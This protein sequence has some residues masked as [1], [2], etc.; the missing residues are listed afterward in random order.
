MFRIVRF[1]RDKEAAYEAQQYRRIEETQRWLLL[2]GGVLYAALGFWLG[3]GIQETT[4]GLTNASVALLLGSMVMWGLTFTPFVRARVELVPIVV[5]LVFGWFLIFAIA[6]VPDSG[7]LKAALLFGSLGALT[8]LMSPMVQTAFAAMITALLMAAVG[9][10]V[11]FPLQGVEIGLFSTL[12]VLAPV[13]LFVAGFALAL[14]HTRREAF[15][16]R[17]ELARRAT[18]DDISGVS[19]RAHIHQIAQNEF[20]RARRYKEPLSV[21]MLE[22]DNFDKILDDSGP[23]ALDTL[24]QVF[25]GYCVVVMRHCDSFGRLGPKRFLAI[26][27]ETPVKGA[28]VLAARMCADLA[29]LDVMADGETLKF[30]ASIGVAEAHANDKWSGDLLRRCAQAVDD[31]I[32]QGRNTAVT[33]LAPPQP[34][35]N[36]PV[37]MMT[38]G[39]ASMMPPAQA[40]PATPEL[41]EPEGPDGP[42]MGSGPANGPVAGPMASPD[43]NPAM[44]PAANP[45]AGPST[46]PKRRAG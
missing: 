11:V 6:F 27:P 19:N 14:D 26:L 25:A 24:I 1:R 41:M 39:A 31:A 40:E 29:A 46:A 36:D 34:Q 2:A 43:S 12:A 37:P 45:S 30:T 33:A 15:S 17:H 4:R 44:R 21:L 38:G 5:S 28:S 23:I 35:A 42:G 9:F 8:A 13:Y 10:G 16:Y 32:E 3:A 18:T 20:G 7:V 22:I